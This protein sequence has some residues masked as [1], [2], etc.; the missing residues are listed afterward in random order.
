MNKR[1]G[2]R[3]HR[4]RYFP[5][6]IFLAVF[7]VMAAMTTVQNY[8]IRD[9]INIDSFSTQAIVTMV[10]YW[11]V[12]STVFTLFTRWQIIRVYDQ[13][14]RLMAKATRDVAG[15]DFSVYVRPLHTADKADYIDFMI[16]DFNKMVAELGS[17]ET[18]KT[19]FFSNVSHEIKTPLAVIQNYAELIQ[20]THLTDQQ[21]KE[22]ASAIIQSTKKLSGLITNILKLNRLEQ[23]RI[24]PTPERYDLCAQLSECA[25]Q[26]EKIWE[27]KDKLDK[28]NREIM[29][30]IIGV[31]IDLRNI[32]WVYRLKKY[33][34]VTRGTIVSALVPIEYNLPHVSLMKMADAADTG[35]ILAEISEGPYKNVIKDFENPERDFIR[36]MRR[37]YFNEILQ[38]PFSVASAAGYIFEKAEEINNITTALEGVR[39][40]LPPTEIMK[41]LCI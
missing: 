37:A 8:I 9:Q 27:E 17:I 2:A 29:T 39:Y 21:R 20:G 6:F 36:V 10:I 7:F 28:E 1:S 13:P 14:M 18:L 30:R 26:F 35:G 11:I 34:N 23:Q 41:Y 22:Y 40:N 38:H 16:E 24:Q 3:R 33:Y 12:I 4:A 25:L 5:L 32:M 31:E 15:G 19:E